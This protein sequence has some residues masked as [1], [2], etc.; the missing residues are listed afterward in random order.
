MAVMLRTLGIP[1]RLVTGYGPGQRNPL[2]GY[3][4]VKQS[5][6]HAW[7]EVYYPGVGWV[8]YDPTFGVPE[9]APSAT[10]RFMAGP[11]FAAIGRFV[12]TAVPQPV[13]AAAGAV[14]RSVASA[15]AIALRA[16]PVALV[17]LLATGPI[18]LALRRWR[19]R[20][21]SEARTP[22]EA[23]F[24][25]LVET[26]RPLGHERPPTVTPSEFLE[27]IAGDRGLDRVVIE[28][29]ETIVRT[30]EQE[31][32]AP[33]DPSEAEVARARDASALVRGLAGRR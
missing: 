20:A 29:A 15:G 33:T 31:R 8:H 25:E 28:A 19:R 21:R 30:F 26:L 12:S 22:G 6:A 24:L 11:V 3:F 18:A 14:V 2:T 32:F 9:A 13:K 27:H 5:D 4:E 17:V 10:S 1:T 23:A 16:W 7:L